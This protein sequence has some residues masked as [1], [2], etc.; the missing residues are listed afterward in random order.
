MFVSIQIQADKSD[1]LTLLVLTTSRHCIIPVAFSASL[2]L[3]ENTSMQHL[4]S[5]LYTMFTPIFVFVAHIFVNLVVNTVSIMLWF[6]FHSKCCEYVWRFYAH[7]V[8]V[9]IHMYCL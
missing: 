1:Y 6:F 5:Y 4:L 7:G 8:R 9:Y 2:F 3:I